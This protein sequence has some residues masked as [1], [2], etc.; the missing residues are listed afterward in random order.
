ML[1]ESLVTDKNKQP[2]NTSCTSVGNATRTKQQR[3]NPFNKPK[4]CLTSKQLLH[5]EKGEY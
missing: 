3:A 4:Q 2:S 5:D 1:I